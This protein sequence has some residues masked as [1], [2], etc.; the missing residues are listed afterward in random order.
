MNLYG[1]DAMVVTPLDTQPAPVRPLTLTE[2][3]PGMKARTIRDAHDNHG[4][5]IPWDSVVTIQYAFALLRV[6]V[7]W[8]DE[9]Y[10]LNPY[11]LEEITMNY[12]DETTE[13]C[14]VRWAAEAKRTV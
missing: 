3:E 10:A 8:G 11:D 1:S 9:L 7:R 6:M 5:V 4:G 13:R 2:C 12:T 14:M